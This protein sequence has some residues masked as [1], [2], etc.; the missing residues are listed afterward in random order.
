MCCIQC[1]FDRARVDQV[2]PDLDLLVND[3]NNYDIANYLIGI[4]WL[5]AIRAIKVALIDAPQKR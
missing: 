5:N 2:I 4:T 3:C 1:V